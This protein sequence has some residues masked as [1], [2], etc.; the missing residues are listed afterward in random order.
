MCCIASDRGTCVRWRLWVSGLLGFLAHAGAQASAQAIPG[1]GESITDIAAS[2]LASSWSVSIENDTFIFGLLEGSDQQYTNGL[3]AV[4]DTD[5][6]ASLLS[7]AR[8]VCQTWLLCFGGP[9]SAYLTRYRLAQTHHTPDTLESFLPKPRSRPYAGLVFGEVELNFATAYS[10]G[11]AGLTSMGLLVGV[12]GKYSYAETAQ[13]GFHMIQEHRDPKGWESNED[14]GLALQLTHRYRISAIADSL[15]LGYG[16]FGLEPELEVALGHPRTHLGISATLRLGS[17]LR[18]FAPGPL[19]PTF[20]ERVPPGRAAL[21]DAPT[22]RWEVFGKAR[23]R[24]IFINRFLERSVRPPEIEPGVFDLSGG[25]RLEL[26]PWA[27]TYILTWRSPEIVRVPYRTS[28]DYGVL[29]LTR[30]LDDGP[31]PGHLARDFSWLLRHVEISGAL[32][33]GWAKLPGIVDPE[34]DRHAMRVIIRTRITDW[35]SLAGFERTGSGLLAPSPDANGDYTDRF[36]RVDGLPLRGAYLRSPWK[37]NNR[38]ISALQL[39]AGRVRAR[40][41]VGECVVSQPRA[42]ICSEDRIGEWTGW[43]FGA[44]YGLELRPQLRL[45]PDLTYSNLGNSAPELWSFVFRASWAHEGL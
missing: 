13:A 9:N 10:G 16:Q 3:H 22:W 39:G 43:Q 37:Q 11:A 32:G 21:P 30:F 35:L 5:G 15:F 29:T 20:A 12:W 25:A 1:P 17:A 8:P 44:Y 40:H 6:D 36:F 2:G 19:E 24:R 41:T 14:F 4:Y 38:W 27:F 45:G 23:A 33:S 26:F 28:H 31:D 18:T 42:E 34:G 7:W